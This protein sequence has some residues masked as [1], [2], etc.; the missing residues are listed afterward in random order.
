MSRRHRYRNPWP[1]TVE[2]GV[3][4]VLRWAVQRRRTPP[5]PDSPAS[6]FPGATAAFRAPRA[7][8][9]ELT[10]TWVG[11]ATTLLQL[12]PLNVLTDP[13]WSDRASP[14]SFAGPR[15]KVP[16][17]VRFEDLPSIDLVLLS[18]DHYDHLDTPTVRRLL[19]HSPDVR[20][21]VPVGVG[22]QLRKLGVTAVGEHGWWDREVASDIGVTVACTPA[23]HF[24]GRTP[25]GRNRSL[26]S[27]WVVQAHGR[28]VYFA[29]DTAWHP[30]F[31]EIARRFGP[32]D[33][34]LIPIGAYSPRWMMSPVHMDPP[35]ALQAYQSIADVHAS[36]GWPPPVMVPIHW[37]TFRLSDEPLDEPP[38][39]LTDLWHDA[40]LPDD[41]LWLLRH[42]ETR[43][44]G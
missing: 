31:G 21:A 14:I 40:A 1:G 43:R 9:G 17:G 23:R 13:M 5:A 28:R 33:V 18:H 27:G 19:K 24:S 7:L 3:G 42:G 34:T 41:V 4:S 26:W 38:R 20:W 39:R 30:D 11:H 6:S 8:Q 16:P 12:G 2:H 32:F 25:W 36:S 37:G 10:V 15:R 35:E 44:G 29:G 22:R